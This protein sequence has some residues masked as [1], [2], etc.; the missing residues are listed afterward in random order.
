MS[1]VRNA[2][3]DITEIMIVHCDSLTKVRPI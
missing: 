1:Q 2:I 3:I